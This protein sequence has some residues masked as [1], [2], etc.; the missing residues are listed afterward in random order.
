MATL[1]DR[2]EADGWGA[3]FQNMRFPGRNTAR[4]IESLKV[5]CSFTTRIPRPPLP[6]AALMMTGQ[7]HSGPVRKAYAKKR[8]RETVFFD[9]SIAVA[10]CV[11]RPGSLRD[12]RD[13]DFY[14]YKY[15]REI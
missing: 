9:E 15:W 11:H 5:D 1:G 12:D 4:S 6:M 13:T 10:V 7:A 2:I 8:T 3:D 14:C